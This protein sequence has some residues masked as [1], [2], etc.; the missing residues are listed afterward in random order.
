[1]LICILVFVVFCLSC[2]VF[3]VLSARKKMCFLK[4]YL[5]SFMYQSGLSSFFS[6]AEV[7]SPKMY[8]VNKREGIHCSMI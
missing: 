7:V 8:E 6:H 5:V 1:M 2:G 4:G 3:L